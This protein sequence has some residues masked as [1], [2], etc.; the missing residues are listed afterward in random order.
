MFCLPFLPSRVAVHSKVNR[1]DYSTLSLHGVTR[2]IAGREPQ[3]TDLDQWVRDLEHFNKLVKIGTFAKFRMWKAFA[4][5][6]KNVRS[7]YLH[8]CTIKD[9][10]IYNVHVHV[11]V[12]IDLCMCQIC[13]VCAIHTAIVSMQRL[14]PDFLSHMLDKMH[15][16]EHN[17]A[18]TYSTPEC[19]LVLHISEKYTSVRS[20]SKRI[21]SSYTHNCLGHSWRS[22][23]VVR[24]T[25]RVS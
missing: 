13:N 15:R 19:V 21:C 4:T 10:S 17:T 16:A 23:V 1:S 2:M 20:H 7:R 9:S 14:F 6:R 12:M 5:W 24:P 22:E 8:Y 3:F 25:T 18:Y 11:H